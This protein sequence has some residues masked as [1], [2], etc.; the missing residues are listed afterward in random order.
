MELSADTYTTG[1][2]PVITI[3]H[4]VGSGALA[5]G[6]L[7]G[8][9][10][11]RWLSGVIAS[12]FFLHPIVTRQNYFKARLP[13]VGIYRRLAGDWYACNPSRQSA[14][15]QMLLTQVLRFYP[16]TGAEERCNSV[17]CLRNC[18]PF[19][20]LWNHINL[21]VATH[22]RLGEIF[23]GVSTDC[24]EHLA[25]MGVSG[26]I[27]DKQARSLVTNENVERLRGVPIFLFAGADNQVYRAGATLRTQ[28]LLQSMFGKQA[29]RR[30]VFEGFGHLD[31]WMSDVASKPGGVFETI[32]KEIDLML[33][34]KP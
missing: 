32:G 31:C 9:I 25:G 14:I 6:L 28:E 12:Q 29:A 8:T 3:A 13:L 7:D 34:Q 30:A 27:N 10:P 22:S 2:E 18:L 5:S 19:G 15:L 33:S 1:S 24:I 21:N 4:C 20:R 11:S 26:T 17:V 23:S 16:H